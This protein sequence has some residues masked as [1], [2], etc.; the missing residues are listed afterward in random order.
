MD[1]IRAMRVFRCVVE[2]QSFSAAARELN[3]VISAVSRHVTELEQHYGCRLL[4]RT[5]RSMSL[6]AEGQLYLSRFEAI[7]ESVDA[8]EQDATERQQTVSGSLRITAP[9]HAAGYG[10]LQPR[11]SQF[12]TRYPDVKLNWL[13][14]NRY[15][16]LVE[17]GVD[18]AVRV[19]QL[20]DSNM[21]ARPLGTLRVYFVASPAYLARAG[22]PESPADLTEHRCVV[23][24]SNRQPGRWR[25]QGKRGEQTIAV[26]ASLEVNDGSVAAQFA[27]D[28]LGIACLPDF[29]VASWLERGE[30]VRVLQN[31]EVPAIPLSLVYPANRLMSPALKALIDTLLGT[32]DSE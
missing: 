3:V 29:I 6:T 27:A 2:Q 14:L 7:L 9:L 4:N 1:L 17:E 16:N 20:E 18:L 10:V 25:Y 28:G 5:T 21:V 8:L 13:L 30:L 15:V 23:D 24:S 32:A 11:V 12:L 26:P 19:G 31:F 22:T